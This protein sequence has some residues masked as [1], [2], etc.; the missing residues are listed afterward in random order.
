M[1]DLA[2]IDTQVNHVREDQD[3]STL[4]WALATETLPKVVAELRAAREVIG[5]AAAIYE[6]GNYDPILFA[7]LG[8]ALAAY[9]KI[10]GEAHHG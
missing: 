8:E 10:T 6:D 2:A 1:I 5:P 3:Q 9:D 7:E 4:A